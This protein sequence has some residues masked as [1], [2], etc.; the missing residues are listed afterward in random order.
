MKPQSVLNPALSPPAPRHDYTLE[1]FD[2][3][4]RGDVVYDDGGERHVWE[5]HL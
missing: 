2:S 5:F 4:Q 3:R 1:F